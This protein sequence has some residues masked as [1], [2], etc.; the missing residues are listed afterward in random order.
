MAEDVA[1]RLVWFSMAEEVSEGAH[2]C[3]GAIT[4]TRSGNE[5]EICPQSDVRLLG[6]HNLLNLLAACALSAEIG[7]PALAMR[8]VATTFSGVDHRLEFVAE[9]NSARRYSGAS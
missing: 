4:V 2:G 1:G 8:T 9:I 6:G 7:V 5:R 3:R